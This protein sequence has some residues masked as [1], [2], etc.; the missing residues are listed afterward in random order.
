MRNHPPQTTHS[1]GRRS[2][3]SMIVTIGPSL[4]SPIATDTASAR[5]S[6]LG[7]PIAVHHVP[8]LQVPSRIEV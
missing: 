4:R 5:S 8:P 7:L 1:C 2:G 6:R 3:V